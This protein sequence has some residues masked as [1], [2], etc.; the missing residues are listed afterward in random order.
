M[1]EDLG[2]FMLTCVQPISRGDRK[3]NGDLSQ[4]QPMHASIEN[5]MH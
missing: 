1:S 3:E 4:K 5:K 2:S